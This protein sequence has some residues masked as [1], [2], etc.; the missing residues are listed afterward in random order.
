MQQYTKD[1]VISELHSIWLKNEQ[2]NWGE[3]KEKSL[4]IKVYTKRKQVVWAAPLEDFYD[5]A[6]IYLNK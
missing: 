6:W 3:R 2:H 1:V 5:Q 4:A